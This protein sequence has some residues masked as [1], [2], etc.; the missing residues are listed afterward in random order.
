MNL[1]RRSALKG[2]AAVAAAAISAGGV[3]AVVNA[4]YVQLLPAAADDARLEE[5]DRAWREAEAEYCRLCDY[6]AD[7]PNA[8]P[9]CQHDRAD[10]ERDAANE[11]AGDA[12]LALA[13]VPAA[14]LHGVLIKLQAWED[15][16]GLDG[17]TTDAGH[18][19]LESA[20]ADLRRLGG[21][22]AS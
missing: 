13:A 12:M 19:V 6:W 15:D 17:N 9:Q 11:R 4:E 20:L 2:S 3:P 22:T 10:A 7:L 1:T 16:G 5:L 14:G 21:E 18:A 8:A